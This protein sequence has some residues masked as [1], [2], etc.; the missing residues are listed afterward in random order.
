MKFILKTVHL[1]GQDVIDKYKRKIKSFNPK[2]EDCKFLDLSGEYNKKV[3]TIELDSLEDLIKFC[4]KTQGEIIVNDKESFWGKTD[5]PILE[6][7][8]DYRE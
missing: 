5:F 7:Y 2:V 3:V 6:I 8:D 1:N 4:R